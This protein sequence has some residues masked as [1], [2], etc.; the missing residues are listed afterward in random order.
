MKQGIVAVLVALALGAPTAA[1]AQTAWDSPLLLPPRAVD[2][3]GIYLTDMHGGGVGVLGTWRSPAWNYGLRFGVS[4]G[5]GDQDIAVF[6]GVDYAGAINVAT[7]DF[8]IDV[9]WVLGVGA[10][11]SD[12]VRLSAPLGLSAGYSF[13]GEGARFTPFITPRVVLDA[14]FGNE[15]DDLDLDVAADFGLD[16]TFTSA[17]GPLAG[18]TIR[19]AVT[20]GDR[21][22]IGL[23]LVF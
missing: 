7:S 9:D 16:L 2:G 14:W 10:G 6:G 8:P 15:D 22:A 1:S 5:A 3:F 13:Q 4:D 19:F 21:N 12:D 20:A 17:G 11:I 18:S 23:G